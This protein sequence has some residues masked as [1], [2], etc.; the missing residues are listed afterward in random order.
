MTI[1]NNYQSSKTASHQ[2][3]KFIQYLNVDE[4]FSFLN[5]RAI[6][7]VDAFFSLTC[8]SRPLTDAPNNLSIKIYFNG[9]K[10]NGQY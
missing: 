1:C 2:R 8:S 9:R 5:K 3:Q 7:I 6:S 4:V 10:Y